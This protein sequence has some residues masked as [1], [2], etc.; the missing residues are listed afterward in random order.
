MGAFANLHANAQDPL[1]KRLVQLVMTDEAFHH[2]FGKIWAGRTIPKLSEDEHARIEDWAA[3]CFETLLFNL[4]NIRQRKAIYA[5]FGLDWEWVR[6]ACREG[7]GERVRRHSLTQ[8]HHLF[9]VLVKKLVGAG[10]GTA[11]P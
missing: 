10:L 8:G 11:R 3:S 1:L 6:D 5:Q 9:R 2:K 7:Y 4:S